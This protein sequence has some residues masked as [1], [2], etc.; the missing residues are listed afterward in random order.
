VDGL[1]TGVVARRGTLLDNCACDPRSE[2]DQTPISPQYLNDIEHDR[3]TPSSD[4]LMKQFAK[5]LKVESDFLFFLAGAIPEEL[6]KEPR[7]QEE[8]VELF[9]AFRR[10]GKR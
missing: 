2:E 1:L 3:R 9:S 5:V 10:T 6:R 4:F 7:T 8:V